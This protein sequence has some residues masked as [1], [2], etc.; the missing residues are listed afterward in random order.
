[1]RW[2][3]NSL[4][5]TLLLFVSL[6]TII[7]ETTT[8]NAII[9]SSPPLEKIGVDFF[10]AKRLRMPP[11]RE[12]EKNPDPLYTSAHEINGLFQ[13][14]R[15][16]FPFFKRLHLIAM[17]TNYKRSPDKA[18]QMRSPLPGLATAQV[19][20]VPADTVADGS[21]KLKTLITRR[22]YVRFR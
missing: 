9:L 5:N 8:K 13:T 19:T 7:S 3:L 22:G 2:W 10:L 16:R 1:M 15:R 4:H 20:V 14:N 17:T 12:G 6:S 21:T 11:F 18:L